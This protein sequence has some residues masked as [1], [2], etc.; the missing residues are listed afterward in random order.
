MLNKIRG[1]SIR[2]R[3]VLVYFLLVFIAM[4]IIAVFIMNQ[5]EAYQM[6]SI[7]K[8]FTR[9]VEENIVSFQE[10]D[11]LEDNI[12]EIQADT[13]AWARSLREELFIVDH[14][15]EVIASSNQNLIGR[16]AMDIL[17]QGLLVQGFSGKNAEADSVLSSGIPVKN[18][19]FPIINDGEVKGIICLRADISSV[20][21]ILHQS[22]LI[23]VRAMLIALAITVVLGFFIAKSIT[24]PINDVTEKAERMS[25]GDFTQVVSVKSNDEIGRL[26]EMFN[27]LQE[28]LNITL[29]DL[30]GEKSKL[31][32][33]L[34]YMVDGLLVTDLSG[35]MIH[36]NSAAM[37]M[38]SISQ[39]DVESKSYD[40]I[41]SACS[42]KLTMEAVLEGSKKGVGQV[43]FECGVTIFLGRY[44]R[45]QDESGQDIGIILLVQDIT[46]RQ[47]LDNMQKDF[48]SNVSHEL[49]TPLTTIKSYT[50]TLLDGGVDDRDT[51][52]YFLSIVDS[53]ADRMNRLVKD[54]LQLSRMDY[55]KD[56]MNK[57]DGN[58][59]ALLNTDIAK[60]EMTARQKGQKMEV[61]YDPDLPISV[62]MDRDGME[63]VFLNILSNAIKYTP[64]GG[65]I[66]VDAAAN[67]GIV[68]I[69][70]EDT[71]IGVS[72]S[73]LPRLF[74]RFYRVDKARSRE[75][76]GTGLGLAIAKQIV[77]EHRG[78]IHM[79]SRLGEGTKVTVAIPLAPMR[80]QRNIE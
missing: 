66:Y 42:D 11:N 47:K 18:M 15:F 69:T 80:G 59:I 48:V 67:D 44:T 68:E 28:K 35:K 12:A 49:K 37:R 17:D 56:S 43:I 27:L 53:E 40:E 54:L 36:V 61:R 63:Q 5:L 25:Q 58:I 34:K 46:E 45:F 14:D 7:R 32:T 64:E 3:I 33:I 73:E 55:S 20:Y 65:S 21:E 26:A 6:E 76:G 4:I 16:N 30:S 74:E 10:Y 70:V 77:E 19:V 39:E 1:G 62:V 9:T 31:E 41:I 38:L 51:V 79:E 29:S 57:M 8:D 13:E 23:F 24:V 50:E 75:M 78:T 2:W 60:V 72:E 71:G 52:N 22:Q